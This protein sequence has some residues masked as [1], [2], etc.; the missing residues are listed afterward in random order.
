MGSPASGWVRLWAPLRKA[1]GSSHE[2]VG[3]IDGLTLVQRHASEQ[4]TAMSK[5]NH[6]RRAVPTADAPP[7]RTPSC[8]R[9]PELERRGADRVSSAD[10][11][12]FTAHIVDGPVI[13]VVNVSRTGILTR[14]EARLMPGAVIGLRVLTADDSVV[15]FGRVVR[16]RLLSIDQNKPLYESA[17]A[18]LREFPLLAASSS[19]GQQAQTSP[20]GRSNEAH[21]VE[22]GRLNGAPVMLTVTAFENDPREDVMKAFDIPE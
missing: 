15:L 2:E 14:S 18:L 22:I 3:P 7:S 6:S 11:P 1:P 19:A 5:V 13:E 17:L 10:L 12:P 16:S 21:P 20:P 9:A 4:V 8:A